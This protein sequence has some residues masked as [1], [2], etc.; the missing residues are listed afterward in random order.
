MDKILLTAEQ[1]VWFLT[2]SVPKLKVL[3][4]KLSTGKYT[5]EWDAEMHEFVLVPVD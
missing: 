4:K 3:L 1:C 5:L 2:Q